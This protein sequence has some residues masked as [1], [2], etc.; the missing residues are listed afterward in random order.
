MSYTKTTDFALQGVLSSNDI[1]RNIRG[2][3]L[4]TEF[5]A[6]ETSSSSTS[7]KE[8]GAVGDGVSDDTAAIQAAFTSGDN[9][10]IDGG[11]LT[12]IFN[13]TVNITSDNVTIQN[14]TLD[15]S[16]ATYTGFQ[17]I[18]YFPGTADAAMIL[19]ADTLIGSN[20]ITVA[21]T[22]TISAD[23]HLRLRSDALFS[24]SAGNQLSQTVEVKSVLNAT[25]LELYNELEFDFKAADN[26]DIAKANLIKN[27]KVLNVNCIGNNTGTVVFTRFNRCI[28]PVVSNCNIEYVSYMG[29]YLYRCVGGV[30]SGCSVNH[31][32]NGNSIGYYISYGCVDT[33][34]ENNTAKDTMAMVIDGGND[35]NLNT[36]ILNNIG[37]T[38]STSIALGVV[39]VNA[40]VKGNLIENGT[41]ITD[42]EV[43]VSALMVS[44]YKQ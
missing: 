42:S 22:S 19:T 39:A 36:K 41:P 38:R 20:V 7:V 26:A 18:L 10:V 11:G 21:D 13:G 33:V 2:T 28:N 35:I 30:V 27:P 16:N 34:I 31:Q 6:L 43:G 24:E 29:V 4:D 44:L 40:V 32:V 8:F 37:R 25:T 3:A 17:S 12:Y 23:D 15:C 9:I 5:D 14:M 1:Q